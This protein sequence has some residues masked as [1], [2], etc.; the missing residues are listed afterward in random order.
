LT[1]NSA[2]ITEARRRLALEPDRSSTAEQIINVT[3]GHVEVR[4]ISAPAERPA[5]NSA[6]TAKLMTLDDYLRQRAQGGRR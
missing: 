4:A 1:S 3:I 2:P 6:S 5:P